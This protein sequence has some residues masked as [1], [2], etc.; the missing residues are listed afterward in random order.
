M[1]HLFIQDF[2]PAWVM[3]KRTD[4]TAGWHMQDNKRNGF[5]Y[6]N[7][8]LF[9]NNS[10]SSTQNSRMDLL[11]NGFKYRD[12]D[13]NYGANIYIAFAEAP[14]VGTNNVPANAR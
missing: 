10:D 4:G 9:A 12:G 2:K 6:Q 7:Y 8:R 14:L 13:G 5:N 11:S 1:V 3:T